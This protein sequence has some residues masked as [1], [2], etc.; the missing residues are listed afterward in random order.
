MTKF[1]KNILE[2]LQLTV[3]RERDS[4]ISEIDRLCFDPI[5]SKDIGEFG[6]PP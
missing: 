2:F 5:F 3:Y 6:I 4:R 1:L